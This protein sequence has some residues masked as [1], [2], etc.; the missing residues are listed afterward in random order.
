MIG[1]KLR[2]DNRRIK[3]AKQIPREDIEELYASSLSG[4]G[5]GTPTRSVRIA[6]GALIIK[7]ALDER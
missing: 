6:P 4:T 5:Q 7:K 3:L 1:G 2:N